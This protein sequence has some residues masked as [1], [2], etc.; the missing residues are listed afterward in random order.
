MKVLYNFRNFSPAYV[1][2]RRL[3][4]FIVLRL[5]VTAEFN[6]LSVFVTNPV[7]KLNFLSFTLRR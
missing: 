4:S 2:P 5:T 3:A 6:G 7:T 1:V